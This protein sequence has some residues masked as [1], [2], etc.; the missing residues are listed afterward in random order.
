MSE[1]TPAIKVILGTKKEVILKQPKISDQETSMQLAS[2]R[3][4]DSPMLLVAFATKELLKLLILQIDGK[5][6]AKIDVEQLDKLFTL[7]EY[8]QLQQVVGKL[9]GGDP[10]MGEYQTEIVI[11]GSK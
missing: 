2:A 11:S 1:S 4:K 5:A 9:S 3:A 6:P 8:N 7:A 10:E